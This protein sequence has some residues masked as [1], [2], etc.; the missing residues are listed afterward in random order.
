MCASSHY[1][2]CESNKDEEAN[3][4]QMMARSTSGTISVEMYYRPTNEGFPTVTI[5]VG[6]GPAPKRTLWSGSLATLLA[7]GNMY[8]MP[9]EK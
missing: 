9:L 6:P 8:Y 3:R 1:L 5:S 7:Y 2:Y 4:V